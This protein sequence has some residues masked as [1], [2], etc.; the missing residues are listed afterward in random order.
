M[1]LLVVSRISVHVP[2]VTDPLA[3]FDAQCSNSVQL[4]SEGVRAVGVYVVVFASD[5]PDALAITYDL[6]TASA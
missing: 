4:S 5:L 6:S 3:P 2:G 1:E